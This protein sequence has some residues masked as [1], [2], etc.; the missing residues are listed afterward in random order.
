MP[1]WTSI[2]IVLCYHR[3][4]YDNLIFGNHYAIYG[5]PSIVRYSACVEIMG[6]NQDESTCTLL[7]N[8]KKTTNI[9]EVALMKERLKINIS[10]FFKNRVFLVVHITI[11]F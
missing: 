3:T 1:V 6:R 7:K 4:D 10:I 8:L 2:L 11:S 9:C 5:I